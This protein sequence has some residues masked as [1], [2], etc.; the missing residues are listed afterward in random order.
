MALTLTENPTMPTTQASEELCEAV[1]KG[2]VCGGRMKV[3][4]SERMAGGR[5]DT[6]VSGNVK[7]VLS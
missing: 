1:Y 2:I 3:K 6:G 7:G 5:G 4:K